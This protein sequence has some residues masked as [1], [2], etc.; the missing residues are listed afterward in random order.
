MAKYRTLNPRKFTLEFRDWRQ[1]SAHGGQLAIAALLEQFGL[2]QRVGRER[3]LDPRTHRG[4]G[5]APPVHV[6]QALFSFTSGGVSLADAE[7]LNEDGPLKAFL[8]VEKFPDQTA[9]GEWL[10]DLGEPGW[11]ALRRLNRA[12]AQWVFERAEPAR[13]QHAGRT[14]CFFDDTQ[15]EVNGISFEGAAMNYEGN[16]A[17]SWQVL[18]CGPLVADQIL[19][20]TSD[21]KESPASDQAGK[22]VSRRLPELLAANAS[23]WRKEQSHLYTDS[24]SSAGR[25]L[26]IIADHFGAWSVSYNKWTG[27]LEK[28]AAE[29]PE[30][31]WSPV[32]QR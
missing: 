10:R 13:Y 19:G 28:K 14:E 21:T 8:G 24:A 17:L 3:A 30:W 23:L 32:Q 16:L 25:Y 5:Y 4:K 29:L 12:F 20:A 27:P 31:S 18:L 22:D 11:Q 15:I 7:R 1:A 9:L 26:E 2:E 6:T